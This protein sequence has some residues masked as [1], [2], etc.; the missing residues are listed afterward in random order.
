[1]LGALG[2]RRSDELC[3]HED[4][5]IRENLRFDKVN[6][7]A[8]VIVN[9]RGQSH[10]LNNSTR[11]RSSSLYNGGTVHT[12]AGGQTNALQFPVEPELQN[13]ST[14]NQRRAT[15][16]SINLVDNHKHRNYLND[17]TFIKQSNLI[18]EHDNQAFSREELLGPDD[19]QADATSGLLGSVWNYLSNIPK[20]RSSPSKA[21]S[22]I[23]NK[24][25]NSLNSSP[26]HR[27][28]KRA[29]TKELYET[30]SEAIWSEK[31]SQET[32]ENN[33]NQLEQHD[34]EKP[35]DPNRKQCT[36]KCICGAGQMPGPTV[37]SSSAYIAACNPSEI[38]AKIHE[39]EKFEFQHYP[40]NKQL[41]KIDTEDWL[42][43]G[44]EMVDYIAYYLET[45][46]KR[47]VTPDVEPG[48]LKHL[49]PREAPKK[50]QEWR[51]I[52]MDFEKCI[53]P[54][55]THWQVSVWSISRVNCRLF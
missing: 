52:M 19:T 31:V 34:N 9:E 49:L 3:A 48:Y 20:K 16:C 18:N 44:K 53:L 17:Q 2:S 51:T 7:L 8:G 33:N 41:S 23:Y 26:V 46:D 43:I 47:R 14:L 32:L 55:I 21:R 5:R 11:N 36:C 12:N 10:L 35:L 39:M 15:S 45:L 30:K 42:R 38:T 37:Q 1:M 13:A 27:L 28:V 40:A 22:T 4:G 54:G 50:A 24:L 25:C 6:K 29:D